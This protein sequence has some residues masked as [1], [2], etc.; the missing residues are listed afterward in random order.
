[1]CLRR[2]LRVPHRERAAKVKLCIYLSSILVAFLQIH[3]IG[4]IAVSGS[5]ISNNKVSCGFLSKYLSPLYVFIS[6]GIIAFILCVVW[7]LLTFKG[8]TRKTLARLVII[9]ISLIIILEFVSAI[10]AGVFE[11]RLENSL[12]KELHDSVQRI[13]GTLLTG[14][15][16]K[17]SDSECWIDLQ[18]KFKC[19]GA[20]HFTDWETA[21]SGG[22]AALNS[23]SYAIYNRVLD[24][25]LCTGDATCDIFGNKTVFA[26]SCH[27]N[28]ATRMEQVF[29]IVRIVAV[30]IGFLQ[31]GTFIL[32]YYIMLKMQQ[33]TAIDVYKI[34]CPQE[35]MTIESIELSNR[36]Q[37]QLSTCRN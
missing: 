23:S 37:Q 12:P 19:C 20:T 29:L 6:A 31:M 4:I 26:S 15:K 17:R 3:A 24:S 5:L 21:A 7:A 14:G 30:I 33:Q 13:L 28:F 25:C 8:K 2:L 32:F 35:N 16:P 36:H 34:K 18:R 27:S 11:P 22:L 10:M 9:C 1:M